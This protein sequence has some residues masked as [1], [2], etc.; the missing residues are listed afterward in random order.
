MA[1]NKLSPVAPGSRPTDGGYQSVNVRP[2]DNGFIVSRSDGDRYSETF[3]A[4]RPTITTG[5][6]KGG[7][8]KMPSSLAKAVKVARGS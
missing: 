7:G 6:A 3:S 4:E 2:I 1:G 5:E 8:P